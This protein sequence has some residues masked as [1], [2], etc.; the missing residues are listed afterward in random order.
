MRT[1][2]IVKLCKFKTAEVSIAFLYSKENEQ[3]VTNQ[4]GLWKKHIFR[5]IDSHSQT[6]TLI[7]HILQ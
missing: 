4:R 1:R 5:F 6:L 2:T 3:C 7:L